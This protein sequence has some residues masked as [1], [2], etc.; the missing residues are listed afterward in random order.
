MYNEKSFKNY[1][2]WTKVRRIFVILL[3]SVIG[4]L[5]G[6]FA[7]DI[8]QTI[9][10]NDSYRIIIISIST[11]LFF[12]IALLLTIG[13]AREV[14]DGY[15]KIAVL[16]KLTVMSKKLDNLGNL[17]KLKEEFNDLEENLEN[18]LDENKY[19]LENEQKIKYKEISKTMN[20]MS[21]N[22]RIISKVKTI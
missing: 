15:W 10:V 5:I 21:K 4:C 13:T 2:F 11:L 9:T 20:N 14:Q 18:R 19:E 8:V 3:F 22:K 1:I 16:R 6:I 17:K 12:A 7:S